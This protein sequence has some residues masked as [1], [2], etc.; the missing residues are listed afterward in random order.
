MWSY[1]FP[2]EGADWRVM[3]VEVVGSRWSLA[4]ELAD[5]V[6]DQFLNRCG[7]KSDY[8]RDAFEELGFGVVDPVAG[9]VGFIV[10]IKTVREDDV[11]EATKLSDVFVL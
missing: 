7:E 11:P 5:S 9:K 2:A 8:V 6:A 10:D 1:D 3:L 4:E